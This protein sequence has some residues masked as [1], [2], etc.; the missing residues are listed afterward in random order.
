LMGDFVVGDGWVV[1]WVGGVGG[2]GGG[3]GG[4]GGFVGILDSRARRGVPKMQLDVD[5]VRQLTKTV[6]RIIPEKR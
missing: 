2:A 3:G 5:E 6:P 4:G 1:W